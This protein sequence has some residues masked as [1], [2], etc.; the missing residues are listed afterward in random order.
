LVAR[1]KALARASVS[2]RVVDLGGLT[3]QAEALSDALGPIGALS[4]T[5]L[6]QDVATLGADLGS[7]SEAARPLIVA[8][9]DVGTADVSCGVRAGRSHGA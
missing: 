7:A 8:M 2:V 1:T 4:V 9:G 6:A 5:A 3:G